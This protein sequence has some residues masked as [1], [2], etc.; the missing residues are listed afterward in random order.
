M[1]KRNYMKNE[2]GLRK[3]RTLIDEQKTVMM[4]SNLNTIP[5]VS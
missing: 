2:E 1:N 3:V 5:S 4:A